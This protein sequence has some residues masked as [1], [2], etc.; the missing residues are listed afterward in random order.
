MFDVHETATTP[1]LMTIGYEGAQISDFIV[2]LKAAKVR[3]LVDVRELPLSRKKG[4]S[5]NALR[6]A[7]ECAGI[8]YLHIRQLGD[9]KPGR[10]AARSG[11]MEKFSRIFGEHL[12]EEATQDALR[13]LVPVVED[14]GAC[15]LCFERDH[16]DCHRSLVA[17]ELSTLMRVNVAHIGVRHGIAG[18]Q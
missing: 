6:E 9:P 3:S 14:G 17:H 1:K 5:K 8:S 13:D 10:D 2:T 11:D 15:L 16:S 7:L 4:F 12:R 18:S